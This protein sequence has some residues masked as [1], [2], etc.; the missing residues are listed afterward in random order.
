[1]IALGIALRDR[2]H[3]VTFCAPEK[4]RTWIMKV[5]F[6][7]VSS[8][9]DFEQLLSTNG[10]VPS[11]L[12]VAVSEVPVQFVSFRDACKEA[13]VVVASGVQLAAPSIAEGFN[14]PYIY[15]IDQAE[16]LRDDYLP[17][18]SMRKAKKMWKKEVKDAINRERDH[19]HLPP[20]NDLSQYLFRSGKLLITFDANRSDLPGW[21]TGPWLSA[22]EDLSTPEAADALKRRLDEHQ[23]ANSGLMKAVSVIED[24]DSRK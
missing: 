18:S 22:T 17:G 1:M 16:M 2:H 13:D 20:M 7:I 12:K 21:T 9:R 11:E 8:G 23:L 6:P 10:D 15:I 24:S 3:T 4:H 19:M 14:I 5:G